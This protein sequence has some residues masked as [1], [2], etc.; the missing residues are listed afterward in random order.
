MKKTILFYR[1]A[2]F[3]KI[4]LLAALIVGGDTAWGGNITVNDDT[5]TSSYFP[6]Y[7]T[8]VNK[9][10]AASQ[11]IIPKDDLGAM[12]GCTINQIILYTN[13]TNT[14]WG[15]ATFKVYLGEVDNTVFSS[16]ELT[17]WS[18]LTEVYHGAVSTNTSKEMVITFDNGF[19]YNG[20]NLLIGFDLQTSASSG[21]GIT[22][23]GYRPATSVK[24]CV[25]Q[26]LDYRNS[27]VTYRDNFIPKVTFSYSGLAAPTEFATSSVSY[28]QAT[29]GWTNGGEETQWQLVCST[30]DNSSATTPTLISSNPYTIEDLS[31]STTYYAYLRAYYSE[32]SQ[33]EWVRT[34]FTTPE[35][36]PTPIDFAIDDFTA[37]TATFSW[38][39][40]TGT[41]ATAWQIKYSTSKGFNPAVSGTLVDGID[42][43]PYTLEGLSE[44]T[45][46]YARIRADYGSSHY[47]SWNTTEI[48]FTP[49]NTINTTVNN[50][51]DKSY[52]LPIQ[53]SSVSS[54]ASSM[55]KSQFVIPSS[56]LSALHNRQITELIFHAENSTISWGTATF[57]VYL[58]EASYTT[59][60]STSFENWGTKVF[61][62][63]TLS[64]SDNEMSITFDTPFNYTNG[65]LQIGFKQTG[66]G[67]NSSSTWLSVKDG[68][69][70]NVAIYGNGT[71]NTGTRTYYSPKVTI[72]TVPVSS[73]YAKI[74][75][76]G[77][78]TFS[79][80]WPLDLSNLPSGLTAY[81]ATASGVK[82]DHVSL[83]PA[84][85]AVSAGTGLI[86]KGTA[87]QTYAIPVADS[88]SDLDGNLMTGV[89][90]LEETVATSDSKYVLVNNNGTPEFQNLSENAATVPGGKAYLDATGIAGAR[91][92]R[93]VFEDEM[94]GIRSMNSE[95]CT[96]N[97][98]VFDLQGR[99]VT[100]GQLMKGLYIQNGKKMIL[101]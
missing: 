22:C 90:T 9:T 96:T 26:Y 24:S 12:K 76:T 54:N 10:S 1:K 27:P 36:Y 34:T 6:F 8:Y 87:G 93:I 97:S 98:A 89:P 42:S 88:G 16:D 63:A 4:A 94:T 41:A 84:T 23:Y 100:N 78:T 5:K 38:T 58:K 29:I 72:T 85:T 68:S 17:S 35:Q 47:S 51:T 65:N 32:D 73:A 83:T 55:V 18:S 37:T 53:G 28:N 56:S 46:Y 20:N 11:S 101:K 80:A 60:S 31:E 2:L 79:S 61:N 25:Y 91:S 64:V 62:S 30:T 75:S 3:M 59:F 45:T 50:G 14:T 77:Y 19:E 95:P 15:T 99:R 7:G 33:S 69:Y 40:G 67:S 70:A 57:E 49:S 81:Y 82:A 21:T 43:N 92:L 71:G 13:N 52:N 39:N 74:G 66:T 44:G 48:E 86:L